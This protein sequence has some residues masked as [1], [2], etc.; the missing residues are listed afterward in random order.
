METLAL[1]YGLMFPLQFLVLPNFHSCFYLTISHRSRGDYHF[2][3]VLVKYQRI[4]KK[5]YPRRISKKFLMELFNCGSSI[6]QVNLMH[7]HCPTFRNFLHA[8]TAFKSTHTVKPDPNIQINFTKHFLT[9]K[10]Y[11]LRAFQWRS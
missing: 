6:M 4:S 5:E 9:V 3:I 7:A 10:Q 1:P 11:Y 2:K 8:L